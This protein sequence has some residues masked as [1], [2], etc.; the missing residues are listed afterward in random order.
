MAHHAKRTKWSS[1][2]I[3]LLLVG[4]VLFQIVAATYLCCLLIFYGPFTTAR[5]YIVETTMSTYTHQYFSTL[6]L[7]KAEI[8]KILAETTVKEAASQ[9]LSDVRLTAGA[10]NSIEEYEIAGKNYH[11]YLLIVRDPTRVKVGITKYL[12]KVGESTSGI[13]EDHNAVAAINGGAFAGGTAWTGTGA[14]PAYFVFSN[15]KLV[16]KQSGFSDSDECNVIALNSK[17]TLIVGN[18]S[19]DDLIRL[20]VTDAVTMSGYQPLIVNGV[21]AYRGSS[22]NGMNPRTAI[23]QAKDGSIFLLVLDGR[24]INML[25]ATPLD[26]QNI[27]LSRGAY[28]A[29]MLDGGSS[30]TM[31]YNGR[32]INQPSGSFGERTVATAFYVEK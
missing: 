13:A 2:K 23:G 19:V 17:G 26:V 31:Y 4:T 14:I 10:S 5:R 22:G 24:R 30:T 7:S 15:G 8:Q 28:N 21:G 29:A 32:V 6:F 9:K 25:G 11:G 16:F 3:F 1:L 20:D 27:L 12:L 18:H